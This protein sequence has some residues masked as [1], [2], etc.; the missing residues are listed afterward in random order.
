MKPGKKPTILQGTSTF[1]VSAFWHGFYQMYYVMFFFAAFFNELCKDIFKSKILF[2]F[3]PYPVSSIVANVLAMIVM[4][5]LGITFGLLTVE[6]GFRFF[7]STSYI[8]P[9]MIF[10]G[11]A[12]F[13]FGGLVKMAQKKQAKLDAKKDDTKKDK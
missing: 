6:E 8:G 11:F 4:N 5:Y 7:K 13:R 9:I 3:I 1:L 2:D 10:S 12:V